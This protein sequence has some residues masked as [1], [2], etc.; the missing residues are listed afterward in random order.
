[1]MSRTIRFLSVLGVLL[2]F[3]GC[4]GFGPAVSK[5]DMGNLELNVVAPQPLDVSAARLYVDGV[6]IG[7]VSSRMPILVLKRGPRT[8]KVELEGAETYTQTLTI[9]GEPNHQVLNVAL[10]K[11]GGG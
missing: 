10:K 8:I 9:L 4:A 5:S 6:F 2:L 11:V 1:M 7:N 3:C